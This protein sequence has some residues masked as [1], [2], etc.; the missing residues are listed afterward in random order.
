MRSHGWD[1][2]SACIAEKHENDR[3]K[4]KSEDDPVQEKPQCIRDRIKVVGSSIKKAA[5]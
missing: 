3:T 4:H 5:L 2:E 1:D